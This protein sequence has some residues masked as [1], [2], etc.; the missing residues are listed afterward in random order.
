[1]KLQI[2]RKYVEAMVDEFPGLVA[3]KEQLRFG[4]KAEVPFQQLSASELGYLQVL[5]QRDGMAM[6]GHVAQLSTL[7]KA[8]NDDKVS[9]AEDDLEMLLPAIARYLINNA[10]RGWLFQANVAGKPMAYLVTRL[11]YTPSG[12]EETGRVTLELKANAKGK[13]AISTV[14][15]RARDIAN[16]TVTEICMAKGFLK[17]TS[18]L[19]RSYDEAAERYFTW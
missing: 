16:K 15:I 18:E 11:D 8:M 9:F 14:T 13:V 12:E 5:Y 1:M 6:Q 4:N 2:E 10:L 19:I 3:L 7:Q 17:E